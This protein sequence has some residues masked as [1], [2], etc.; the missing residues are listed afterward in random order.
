MGVKLL[1]PLD[2]FHDAKERLAWTYEEQQYLFAACTRFGR[3][4]ANINHLTLTIEENIAMPF[5]LLS[6]DI[7]MLV[8]IIVKLC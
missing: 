2:T 5:A 1:F 4:S 3:K 8:P 7:T 6:T